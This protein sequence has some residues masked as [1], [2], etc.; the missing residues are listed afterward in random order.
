MSLPALEARGVCK[1]FGGVA[2]LQDVDFTGYSGEV[3][4]LLGENGAGKSTFV[5]LVV[6]ALRPDAGDIAVLG[7]RLPKTNSPARAAQFGIAAVLQEIALIPDLT[8]SQN[9]WFR[10]ES[11]NRLG[12]IS[13]RK[14]VLLTEELFHRL[15]IH[16]ISPAALVSDLSIADRQVVDI[17]RAAARSPRLLVL[18]EATSALSPGEVKWALA[19]ARRMASEGSLVIFISHRLREVRQVADRI[20]IFRNA[21]AVASH[22]MEEISDDALISEMLGRPPQQLYPPQRRPPTSEPVLEVRGLGA[23]HRLQN[24]DF[25]LH[26]GEIIGV[27]GLQGQ[28]QS[29][30]LLAL[31][32]LLPKTGEIK[33]RGRTA[34]IRNSRQALRA[35][36]ALI[37]EDRQR[38]GLLL[39]KTIRQNAS[40]SVLRK[41]SVLGLLRLGQEA[42]MV[43][44]MIKKLNVQAVS[45]EQIVRTLSGG[46]QQKVLIARVLLTDARILLLNDP[47]RGV[48]IGTKAD[49]FL[50][51]RQLTAEG[52]G[53]ILHSTDFQELVNLSDRVLILRDGQISA[54]LQ[55]ET[56]TEPNALS[57]SVGRYAA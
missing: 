21:R 45:I 9:V 34:R 32:G 52:F 13:E 27:G 17:A 53:I 20:T 38:Q 8:V 6:G 24:V 1:S 7:H 3:L 57:A 12:L 11:R 49:V 40:L 47:V 42:L 2:A 36:I 54:S 31:A 26:E 4:G 55:A 19:L 37:P 22:R 30:L 25:V 43:R 15:D 16:H 48:D 5:K 56:L 23:G 41:F 14:L 28:G 46:N 44:S 29:E 51:L 33:V 50:L 18:D 10:N 39:S 35:G